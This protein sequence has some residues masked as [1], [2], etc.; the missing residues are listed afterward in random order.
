MSDLLRI[1]SAEL[2]KLRRTWALRLAL[3]APLFIALLVFGAYTR[4]EATVSATVNPLTG[5][6]QLVLTLWTIVLLPLYVALAAALLA[7]IE[8]QH[9]TWKHV[10]ALPVGRVPIFVAKWIAGLG[11][12]LLSAVLLPVLVVLAAAGLR[13]LKPAWHDAALPVALVF[14]GSLLSALAAGLLYSIQMWISLRWRSFVMGLG[15]AIIA[16]MVM[17]VAMPRAGAQSA[18][19]NIFPWSLPA[20]AM[21]PESPHRAAAVSLGAVGGV[22]FAALACWSLARRD[23]Y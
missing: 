17:L 12:L 7:A 19:A 9:D 13:L 18:F 16:M 5:F 14:R 21:A 20:M 8:H 22:A 11:L 3:A 23:V 2:L 1:L 10:L 15:V 6:G 4:R